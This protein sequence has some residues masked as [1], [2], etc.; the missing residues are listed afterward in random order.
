M[1]TV[2]DAIAEMY[3]LMDQYSEFGASDT[4]PRG[5]FAHL[6]QTQ[7]EGRGVRVPSTA[8]EWQLFSGM[9]GAEAAARALHDKTLAVLEIAN[10]DHRGFV[11]A[12]NYYF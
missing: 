5:E 7:L 4:E 8:S 11:A 9:P 12:M 1:S 10:G 3:E 2:K 6:L